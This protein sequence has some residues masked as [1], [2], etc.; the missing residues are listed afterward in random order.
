MRIELFGR[1]Y[2]RTDRVQ[3]TLEELGVPYE[4]RKLDVFALE[5]R[6]GELRDLYGLTRL[7][8]VRLDDEVLFESGAIML[9][10]AEHFRSKVDLLPESGSVDYREV[11][12]WLFFAVSTL[13]AADESLPSN[14]EPTAFAPLVDVLTFLEE[15]L[16]ERTCIAASRFTIA[17]IALSN[18]LKYVDDD[19]SGYPH[20]LFQRAHQPSRV[21]E[22]AGPARVQGEPVIAFNHSARLGW[23]RVRVSRSRS[24]N[25]TPN[26][27]R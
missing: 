4:Y 7:P 17:D 18:N 6:S 22:D 3:W 12:Q 27:R 16:A 26:S 15:T 11:L 9:A 14:A 8:F 1:P 10:L 19:F 24:R 25:R 21:S 2:N 5:H 23:A 20:M 13:D